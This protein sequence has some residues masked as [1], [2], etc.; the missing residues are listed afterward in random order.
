MEIEKRTTGL[1]RHQ[2][3]MLIE[4]IDARRRELIIEI[5]R[6]DKAGIAARELER[7]NKFQQKLLKMLDRFVG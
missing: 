1:N 3:E 2:V 6:G 7:I 4:C 5:Q